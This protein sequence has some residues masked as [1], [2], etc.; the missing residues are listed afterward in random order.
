MAITSE[1]QIIDITAISNGCTIIEEAARDY[2]TCAEKVTEAAS[3]CTAEALSVEK[4][5]MQT[6]LEELGQ[7]IGIIQDNIELFTSE[8]RSVA[9]EIQTRQLAELAA[10]KAAQAA[11]EADTN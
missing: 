7:T 10:Y 2:A 9:L 1:S 6:P 5:S 8:I 3:I 11:Q 4:T